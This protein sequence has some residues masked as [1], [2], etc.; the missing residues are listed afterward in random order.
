LK[1]KVIAM[2]NGQTNHQL[3][4][5]SPPV[6]LVILVVLG[7]LLAACGS[8]SEEVSET[9]QVSGVRVGSFDFAE[10]ELVAEL[11]SQVLESHGLVVL[12]LGAIGPREIVGPAIEAGLIDLVPEYTGTAARHYSVGI[13]GEEALTIDEAL[14]RRG[15]VMLDPAPAENVNVFVVTAESASLHRFER[16]SDLSSWDGLLRLGGPV[17]CST[18]PFC[19]AGLSEVYGLKFA[20]FV[21][22]RS[23]AMT[24]EALLRTEIDVGVMFSTA[25]ELRSESLLVLEDDRNLQPDEQ[26]VPL[27]RI[28]AIERWGPALTD[29]LNELSSQLTT[30]E[31]QRLNQAAAEGIPPATVVSDWLA[32]RT[33]ES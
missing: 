31:L 28:D 9:D 27:V 33:D 8:S 2:H 21:P 19:L 13:D 25:T 1:G 16:I 17:E 5:R 15:L 22:Q 14:E 10:S 26:V 24:A 32:S 29:G 20:E 3:I 6:G 11:Y 18:R 12:R 30:D 4:T 7:V 23:L